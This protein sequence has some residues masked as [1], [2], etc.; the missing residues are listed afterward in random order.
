MGYKLE[1]CCDTPIIFGE[2][3]CSIIYEI[4]VNQEDGTL[5]TTKSGIL[6]QD[7]IEIKCHNC[8][9]P[10]ATINEDFKDNFQGFAKID[11]I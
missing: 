10:V 7:D 8:K 2:Q 9:A 3:D 5:I 6:F 11:L 4:T 1:K